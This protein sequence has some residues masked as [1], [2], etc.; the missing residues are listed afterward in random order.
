MSLYRNKI[1]GAKRMIRYLSKC[2]IFYITTFDVDYYISTIQFYDIQAHHNE[3]K[4]FH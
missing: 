3:T 1:A 4:L 2:L